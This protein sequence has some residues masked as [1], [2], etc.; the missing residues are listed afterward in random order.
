MGST[1]PEVERLQRALNRDPNTTL[2]LRVPDGI[3]GTNTE[4]RVEEFQRVNGLLVDGKVGE[5]TR[6]TLYKTDFSFR[7]AQ[8]PVVRQK[9]VW[10]CW[11]AALES[12][13]VL[14]P[15]ST[16]WRWADLLDSWVG[17]TP[18]RPPTTIQDKLQRQFRQVVTSTGG[19]RTPDGILLLLKTLGIQYQM[20]RGVDLR[21]EIVYSH[22]RKHGH[23]LLIYGQGASHT[24]VVYGVRIV[25]GQRP[26]FL[27]MN[28]AIGLDVVELGI[29][30]QY[31]AVFV[32]WL[33]PA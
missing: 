9:D 11:A 21:G 7:L 24:L 14:T 18:S 10:W 5:F 17:T 28:P 29:I 25:H 27:A 16:W 8:P 12:W 30:Q 32:G 1:G 6:A 33:D 26:E 2:P 15:R 19:L 4:K 20:M 3:F 13:L 23:L 22:L 31:L